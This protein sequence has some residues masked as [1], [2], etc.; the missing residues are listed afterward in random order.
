M[1]EGIDM[2]RV[3]AGILVKNGLYLIAKRR[4]GD[5]L[6]NYWEFPGGKIETGETPEEC[7]HREMSEELQ[8]DVEVGRFFCESIY[9][10]EFGVIQLFIY[11]MSWQGGCLYPTVHDEI[12]WVDNETILNYKF[13]PADIPI[14]NKLILYQFE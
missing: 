13:L 14:V 11:W 2:K 10:Y 9:E 4:A 6:E 3:A 1:K 8:I 7:L 12:A 5:P